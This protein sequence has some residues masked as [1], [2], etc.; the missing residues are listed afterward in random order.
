MPRHHPRRVAGATD[1]VV[2]VGAG[3][4]GLAARCGWPAP[5]ASDRA[6]TGG[7]AGRPGRAAVRPR[8]RVRHRPDRADHARPDRRG[9]RRVGESSP[10]GSTL[11][12]LD[13]AYRAVLP[14]RLDARRHRRP[15]RDGRRDRPGLRAAGGRR[16]P[17]LRRV[18]PQLYAGA[19]DFID[20]NLDTPRDL[21]TPN[22]PGWS[23]SAGSAGCAEVDQFLQDPRTRRVFS[24]QAMYAGLAPHDALASTRSSPTSTR[25][26][27]STSPGRHARRAEGAGR[28]RGEARRRLPL[29][30]RT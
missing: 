22:L 11:D 28:R 10:T 24:F 5:V 17:P 25:S 27:G 18:R 2:V 7:R 15:G 26:P 14:R 13:P 29:R 16:L 23:R 9:L 20:R 19:H 12:P 21:L 1:H 6:R 8:V 4:G 30:H 3:L